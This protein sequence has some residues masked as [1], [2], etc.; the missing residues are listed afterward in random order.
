MSHTIKNIPN[1]EIEITITVT[2]KTYQP[3]LEAA[4]KRISTRM[5]VKGF[6]KG[7]VPYDMMKKEVGE[8]ALLQEALQSIVQATYV[9]AIQKEDLEI[10]GTPQIDLVKNAPGND[11]VYK[12]TVALLPKVTLADAS[13]LTVKRKD[14]TIEDAKVSETIEALRGMHAQE[15][16]KEGPA[17][18]TD[19][20]VIDMDMT[21]DKVAVEG[22]QAKD[23]QVYLSEDHYI[24][25]FNKE[26]EGLKKGDTKKFSLEF[27][28]THYQKH[29]AG[30]TADFAVTV[31]EVFTRELP[32]LNDEFA[33]K[34]GQKDLKALTD[35]ITSNLEN[36]AKQKTNQQ[37]EIDILDAMIEKTTFEDIPEVLINSERQKM[38]YELQRDLERNGVSVE[39]Y[40]QDIKQTQEELYEGFRN[41]ALKRAKAALISRQ[42]ALEKEIHVTDEEVDNEIELMK[43][44]YEHNKEAQDNLKKPEVRDS[45]ATVLQNKKVVAWLKE[46]VAGDTNSKKEKTEKKDTKK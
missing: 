19:K 8:M 42:V 33:K 14:I 18:G 28:K 17:T 31:K 5:A 20:L 45:I 24:P 37:Y 7:N 11:I 29:L 3:H 10:V 15:I 46:Q 34:L 35:I 21:V 32:E 4:A 9:E 44:A 40:M 13:K 26:V 43:Q 41:Q 16:V 30:K 36:E 1:S 12:A 39:Q 38:F 23:Y 27:P 6:R 25:G 22:G 2:P